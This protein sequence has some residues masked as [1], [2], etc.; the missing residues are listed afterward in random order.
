MR[1]PSRRRRGRARRPTAR[2]PCRP[3]LRPRPIRSV[4]IC[5]RPKCRRWTFRGCRRAS[6]SW[7][8][9]AS[10]WASCGPF[11]RRRRSAR[12]PTRPSAWG[13][14][15]R[16]PST[17]RSSAA[18]PAGRR[19]E[20]ER[21]RSWR[22]SGRVKRRRRP[23]WRARGWALTSSGR[24]R[25]PWVSIHATPWRRPSLS[26][27]RTRGI[28]TAPWRPTM[29]AWRPTSRGSASRWPWARLGAKTRN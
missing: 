15:R 24:S 25:T 1:R 4:S 26:G 14:T 17:S 9:R 8:T 7:P 28:S 10:R 5:R 27:R 16:A 21:L 18:L 3:S 12:S 22:P 13:A 23:K 2:R 29:P 11:R 20:P 6:R 19:R